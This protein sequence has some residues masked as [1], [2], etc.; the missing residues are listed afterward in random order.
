MD[1]SFEIDVLTRRV[2]ELEQQL[3]QRSTALIKANQ[4]LETFTYK[5]SHDLHAPL[6]AINSYIE[7]I[8][9]D[10][11]GKPL[12][13]DAFRM[14][15]RVTTNAEE[16]KQMLDG[17]L[18]FVRIGKKELNKKMISTTHLVNE[19][20][21]EVQTN[22]PSRKLIFNIQNLP[23]VYADEELIRKVWMH[24][25]SNAV[26]FTKKKEESII[27]IYVSKQDDAL[28]YSIKDNGDGFDM[29]FYNR[30]FGVFQRLHHKTEFDGIGIGLAIAHK[31]ITRHLGKVWAEAKVREGATFYFSLPG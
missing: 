6:R 20:C 1:K 23:D 12:D 25:I 7:M 21:Q 19:I 27:E 11:N 30:L 31:I 16:M 24:L 3:E 17:L 10:Y 13:A 4:D 26:K 2:Q 29:S 14:I 9:N 5:I 28:V 18:E 22:Y 15:A 8:R